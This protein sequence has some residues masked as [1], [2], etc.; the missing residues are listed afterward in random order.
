VAALV[1]LHV[2]AKRYLVSVEPEYRSLLSA[3]SARTL[4]VQGEAM[5]PD[6]IARFEA[7]PYAHHAI[8]LRRADELAKVPGRDVPSLEDWMP[9]LEAT[10]AMAR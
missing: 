3:G 9:V 5:G 10:M 4:V 7:E 6:E 8:V 2:D 1:E